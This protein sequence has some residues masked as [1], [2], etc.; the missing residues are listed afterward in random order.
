MS[1]EQDIDLGLVNANDVSEVF[2]KTPDR[3][4]FPL[5]SPERGNSSGRRTSNT[6]IPGDPELS[7]RQERAHIRRPSL[8]K[9]L[10][11]SR[12]Y[13]LPRKY[14]RSPSQATTPV[15]ETSFDPEIVTKLRRWILSIIVGEHT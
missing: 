4:T 13:T 1:D 14:P 9:Q 3:T 11:R 15:F 5:P 8:L 7:E 12:S 2:V 6:F 10:S